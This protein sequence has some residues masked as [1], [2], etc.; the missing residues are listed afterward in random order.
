MESKAASPGPGISPIAAAFASS[1]KEVEKPPKAKS[2][3]AKAKATPNAAKQKA[4]ASAPSKAKAAT[5]TRHVTTPALKT[6]SKAKAGSL[7]Y[8]TLLPQ[9]RKQLTE[10]LNESME[11]KSPNASQPIL[12]LDECAKASEEKVDADMIQ[13]CLEKHGQTAATSPYLSVEVQDAKVEQPGEPQPQQQDDLPVAVP[14]TLEEKMKLEL[15]VAKSPVAGT[16]PPVAEKKVESMDTMEVEQPGPPQPQQDALPL[17]TPC[18]EK[19]SGDAADGQHDVAGGDVGGTE[20]AVAEKKVESMEV[21][22]PGPPQP[23][24]DALP[25]ATPCDEKM[26]GDAA[27]GQTMPEQQHDVAGGDVAGPVA[28]KKVE[29]MEVEQPGHPQQDALPVATPCDEKMSGDAADG[30]TMP[31]QQHDVAGGDVAGTA[32]PVAEKKESMEVEQPGE[33][34]P[35]QDDLAVAVPTILE[36]ADSGED[37]AGTERPVAEKKVESMEVEQPGEPRPQQ[38]DLAVAVPTILE[39]ADS[40]EDVAGTERPVAEKKVESMEVEQPGPPQPEQDALP[41][42]TPCDEKMSGVAADGQT[43]P[44]QQHG[45]TPHNDDSCSSSSLSTDSDMREISEALAMELENGGRAF[46]MTIVLRNT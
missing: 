31:E 30:Q 22:Q 6:E 35:Q 45:T 21:E 23:E 46:P 10:S 41:V 33:P 28:E 19:M 24:Q 42:A 18:D 40:G 44:E 20:T 16:E 25:V 9:E 12:S 17:P 39:A 29:S 7:N 27:D 14:T 36:A 26:S 34:R 8:S 4:K 13:S 32:R 5:P 38:D 2:K 15:D 11:M 3:D 1:S 43:M 37:V